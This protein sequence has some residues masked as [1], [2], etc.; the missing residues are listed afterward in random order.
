MGG[1]SKGVTVNFMCQ[2]DPDSC[3]NISPDVAVKVFFYVINISISRL[4][5]Q[6]IILHNVIGL[7]LISRRS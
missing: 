1:I 7:H 4:L 3:L 5:I 6:Q 2:L